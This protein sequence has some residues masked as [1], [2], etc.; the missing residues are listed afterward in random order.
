M[1]RE[2]ES[3]QANAAGGRMYFQHSAMSSNAR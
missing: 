2:R 3:R 1:Q